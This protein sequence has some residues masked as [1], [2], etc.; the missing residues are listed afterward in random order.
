MDNKENCKV[1]WSKINSESIDMD[2]L[3]DMC[4]WKEAD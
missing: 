4:S 3:Q 1:D 2:S